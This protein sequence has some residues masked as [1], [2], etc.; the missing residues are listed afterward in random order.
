[1]ITCEVEGVHKGVTEASQQAA[2]DARARLRYRGREPEA[3]SPAADEQ[4]DVADEAVVGAG[5]DSAVSATFFCV[6]PQ[7]G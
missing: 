4:A 1:M 2:R 6:T 5:A 3:A 7:L